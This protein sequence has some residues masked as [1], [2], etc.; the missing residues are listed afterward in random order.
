VSRRK[1]KLSYE[2]MVRKRD[3]TRKEIEE[4]EAEILKL[5]GKI[6]AKP[7]DGEPKKRLNPA[8]WN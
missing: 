3:E 6:P 7:K 4:I 1:K 2:D 8:E 5:G